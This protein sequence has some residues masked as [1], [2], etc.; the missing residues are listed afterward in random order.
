MYVLRLTVI[1]ALSTLFCIFLL[2]PLAYRIGLVDR[3]GGRKKHVYHTPLIG[4]IAMFFGFCF[5]LLTLD[6]SLQPYRGL[7]AGSSVLILM[8]VVDDFKSLSSKLRL[9][10]QFLAATFLI[11]WGVIYSAT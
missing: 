10:G 1:A 4:G 11:A 2:R 9:L 6:I 5:S 3:P 8:G 7:I